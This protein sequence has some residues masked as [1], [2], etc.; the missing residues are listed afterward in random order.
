MLE[1]LG[2]VSVILLLAVVVL[3]LALLGRSRRGGAG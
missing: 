2:I 3:L 1:V